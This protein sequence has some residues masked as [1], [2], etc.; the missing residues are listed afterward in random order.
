MKA[1]ILFF[2]PSSHREI[3]NL[4]ELKIVFLWYV[5]KRWVLLKENCLAY[6]GE[7]RIV[8]CS[9]YFMINAFQGFVKF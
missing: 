5:T 6:Y 7:E 9:N 2:S 4:K 8:L 1:L 3:S